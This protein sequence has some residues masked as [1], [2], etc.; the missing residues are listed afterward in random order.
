MQDNSK[1]YGF[2]IVIHTCLTVF[3]MIGTMCLVSSHEVDFQRLKMDHEG[4][5]QRLKM[6]N[7]TVTNMFHKLVDGIFEHCAHWQEVNKLGEKWSFDTS[8]ALKERVNEQVKIIENIL[9]EALPE[10]QAAIR[11]YLPYYFICQCDHLKSDFEQ[12]QRRLLTKLLFYPSQYWAT[13]AYLKKAN[14]MGIEIDES[15]LKFYTEN[16]NMLHL[17]NQSSPEF[18]SLRSEDLLS[19]NKPVQPAKNIPAPPP[20]TAKATWTAR[21]YKGKGTARD[22]ST[23]Q[24]NS[25]VSSI[26]DIIRK[27][28]Y[29]LRSVSIDPSK[30]P[31]KVYS[32]P[33]EEILRK[34]FQS[35]RPSLTG[36]Q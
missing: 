22:T 36:T 11:S 19:S 6:E 3:M 25:S 14:E 35:M 28:E 7:E 33:L 9:G 2:N 27:K 8:S 1:Q 26:V 31:K 24:S 17:K 32:N 21:P 15:Y 20:L 16:K 10:N 18:F 30:L 12:T 4:T 34:R 13:V 5:F 23:K 29:V